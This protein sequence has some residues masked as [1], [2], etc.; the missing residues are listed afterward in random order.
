MP[1][2]RAVKTWYSAERRGFITLQDDVLGIV[3]QVR[4]LYG[5]QVTIEMDEDQGVFH[6]VGHDSELGEDYLIFTVDAV[7]QRALDRLVQADS[8]GRGFRD[9]YDEVESAQDRLD[10]A[11]EQAQREMVG[12]I[13][14]ELLFHIQREGKAPRLSKAIYIPRSLVDDA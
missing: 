1:T 2:L 11:K 13:G 6:F 5:D 12:A 4:R 8:Q 14:E 9:S 10:R 7:D 3:G